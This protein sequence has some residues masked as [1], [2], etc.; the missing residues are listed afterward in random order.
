ASCHAV[1]GGEPFASLLPPC[2]VRRARKPAPAFA[3]ECQRI[4]DRLGAVAPGR[5]ERSAER[6]PFEL[7]PDAP[8][9][10]IEMLVETVAVSLHECQLGLN[11]MEQPV[12]HD[13]LACIG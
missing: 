13:L 2:V 12:K 11:A 5:L 9:E 4:G 3:S 1:V 10:G 7:H 6:P 8:F